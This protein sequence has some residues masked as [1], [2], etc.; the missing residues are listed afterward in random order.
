MR[1]RHSTFG[2]WGVAK[3]L[4]PDGRVYVKWDNPRSLLDTFCYVHNLIFRVPAV[5]VS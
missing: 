5:S 4:L 3:K 1:V 2:D